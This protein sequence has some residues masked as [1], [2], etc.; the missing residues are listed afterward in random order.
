[1]VSRL[2]LGTTSYIYPDDIIANARKLA[3]RISDIELVIFQVDHYGNNLPDLE[4]VKEL[5]RLGAEH[6]MTYT[7]HLP[8]DLGLAGETPNLEKA[9]QVIR[10]TSGLTPHG[11]IVHLDEHTSRGSYDLKR[12]EANS[13]ASLNILIRETG[14]PHL[15]CVENLENQHPDM[16]DSLLEQLPIS[17]CPD[18]GHFWKQGL[19]PLPFLERWL[20]RSRVVHIHGI[21]KRDHQSLSLVT[22]E[23]LDPV[24]RLLSRSFRGVVTIEVFSETDLEDSLVALGDSLKRM[25]GAEEETRTPTGLRPPDPEPGAS[26]TSATSA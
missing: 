11:Y 13:L 23:K 5:F 25:N 22:N 7:V 24:V 17:S 4:T 1:M 14:A 10:S 9:L 21:G 16:I 15:I 8:L 3:G 2:R 19:D 6:G 12:W 18:V 20:P 26:T